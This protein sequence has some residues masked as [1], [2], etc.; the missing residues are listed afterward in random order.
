MKKKSRSKRTKEPARKQPA[1]KGAP[2][3]QGAGVVQTPGTGV[4]V[5]RHNILH[6]AKG[7][8]ILTQLSVI[9][10]DLGGAA[11]RLTQ[12]G[13]TEGLRCVV[14]TGEWL[15][16]NGIYWAPAVRSRL[17]S[18]LTEVSSDLKAEAKE[19]ETRDEKLSKAMK[20]FAK[21]LLTRYALDGVLEVAS[22]IPDVETELHDLNQPTVFGEGEVGSRRR[23]IATPAGIVELADNGK[24]LFHEHGDPT[25]LITRCTAVPYQKNARDDALDDF[26]RATGMSSAMWKYFCEVI[27]SGLFQRTMHALILYSLFA[28]TG[29]STL[30]ELAMKSLGSYACK[31]DGTRLTKSMQPSTDNG[32]WMLSGV[33][34]AWVDEIAEDDKLADGR[35]RELITSIELTTKRKYRDEGLLYATHSLLIASNTFPLCDA[36]DPTLRRRIK[37]FPMNKKIDNDDDPNPGRRLKLINSPSAQRAM[38]A[39]LIQ[40]ARRWAKRGFRFDIPQEVIDGTNQFFEDLQARTGGTSTKTLR[41]Q[42]DETAAYIEQ[43]VSEGLEYGDGYRVTV[44]E[45]QSRLPSV[46]GKLIDTKQITAALREKKLKDRRSK[47]GR[48]WQGAKLRDDWTV[49][50]K[51]LELP[52]TIFTDTSPEAATAAADRA[53]GRRQ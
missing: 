38:L 29:K 23:K 53:L 26:V 48:W 3:A 50:R 36:D 7:R 35:F 17:R 20:A 9:D 52:A 11:A 43:L 46:G 27:G 42:H 31:W 1:K 22:A 33:A 24:I 8:R 15:E 40:G 30:V 41:R 25:D 6:D 44:T 2:P 13:Y 39:A 21:R 12:C 18:Y 14:E 37:A 28:L 4:A 34:W 47:R 16:F 19:A 45:I 5:T 51:V 49:Q 10:L 32:L